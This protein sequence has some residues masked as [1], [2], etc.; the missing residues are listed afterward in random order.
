MTGRI[1]ARNPR[2]LGRSPVRPPG[3]CRLVVT[4]MAR[5]VEVARYGYWGIGCCSKYSSG[6]CLPTTDDDRVRISPTD[7]VPVAT[8]PSERHRDRTRIPSV[9]SWVC[10]P[11]ASRSDR[12]CWLGASSTRSG[13]RR[14]CRP[15][16]RIHRPAHV[17]VMPPS[18][19]P[20][21]TILRGGPQDFEC[22]MERQ[23][24]LPE[25]ADEGP[26]SEWGRCLGDAAVSLPRRNRAY[27]LLESSRE[28][29]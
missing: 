15:T 19:V 11:L 14:K 9:S 17:F 4:D 18:A 10:C 29:R 6:P 28:G 20:P 8:P 24:A 27:N 23:T 26:S 5:A 21:A 25:L 12:R 7:T 3:R 16:G 22:R 13:P 2:S 1:R